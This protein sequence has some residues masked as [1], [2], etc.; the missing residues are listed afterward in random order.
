MNAVLAADIQAGASTRSAKLKWVIVADPSR[1]PGLVANATACLGAAAAA[2]LPDLIGGEVEDASGHVHAGLP[3]S[4]CSILA[5]DAGKLHEIRAKAA[6]KEGVFIADMTKHAQASRSYEEYRAGLGE[7][8]EGDLEYYAI[9]LIGPRNKIA[10][11]VGG[12][13][14]LS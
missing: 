13:P 3:W 1:G 11:L 10:K 6:T 9:G 12:L 7:T 5:A 14:L 2:V 4:G 8:G